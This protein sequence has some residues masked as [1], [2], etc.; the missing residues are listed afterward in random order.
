MEFVNRQ[1]YIMGKINNKTHFIKEAQLYREILSELKEFY[2]DTNNIPHE[3]EKLIQG[4]ELNTS[5][6]KDTIDQALAFHIKNKNVIKAKG[7][8]LILQ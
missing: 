2:D 8:F 1:G 3:R 6:D 4:L 5:Y 7:K